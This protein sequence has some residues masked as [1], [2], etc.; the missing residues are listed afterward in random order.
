[1]LINLFWP[2]GPRI[3]PVLPD[4]TCG[5]RFACVSHT[6]TNPHTHGDSYDNA[7]LNPNIR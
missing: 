5:F 6:I 4:F 2:D 1:V 7:N 3:L